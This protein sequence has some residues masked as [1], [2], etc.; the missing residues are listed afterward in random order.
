MRE[1]L[2]AQWLDRKHRQPVRSAP[3]F[4]D[5]ALLFG[6]GTELS[7]PEG[8]DRDRRLALLA[9]AANGHLSKQAVLQLDA[10]IDDW[11]RGDRAMA[12]IRL[13]FAPLPRID[14]PDDAYRLFLAEKALDAGLSAH[15]LLAELGYEDAGEMLSKDWRTQPRWPAGSDQGGEFAPVGAGIV[16]VLLDTT[17]QHQL[18][19]QQRR[20]L[21]QPEPYADSIPNGHALDLL[22]D[23]GAPL[24]AP[25]ATPDPPEKTEEDREGPACPPRR[26]DRPRGPNDKADFREWLIAQLVNPS[27]PTPKRTEFEPTVRSQAYYLPLPGKP[28]G[29]ISFDDCKR[30]D[31]PSTILGLRKGDMVEVK[32]DGASFTY[33]AQGTQGFQNTDRQI[34][35]QNASIALEGEGRRVFYCVGN[36]SD[37]AFLRKKY[38]DYVLTSRFAVCH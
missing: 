22:Q 6:C 28:T 8:S 37:A 20:E 30:T 26:P 33:R 18:E 12:S 2:T 9:V 16:P 13:A 29:E 17:R 25:E 21:G 5:R 10:A 14:G 4:T 31:E 27:D 7:S 23:P 24:L 15:D 38:E 1:T 35:D 36:E 32:D 3:A 11:R 19:T 34:R